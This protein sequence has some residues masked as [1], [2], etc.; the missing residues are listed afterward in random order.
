MSAGRRETLWM[1]VFIGGI[2]LVAV[3]GTLL[4]RTTMMRREKNRCVRVQPID[5]IAGRI[6]E[7]SGVFSDGS[8]RYWLIYSGEHKLT[9]EP[10]EARCRVTEAEYERQMYGKDE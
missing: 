7:S 2:V 6:D 1:A 10:C 9:G 8:T 3:C 4:L 5:L